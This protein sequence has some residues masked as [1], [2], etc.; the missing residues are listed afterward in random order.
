MT[1]YKDNFDDEIDLGKIASVFFLFGVLSLLMSWYYSSDAETLYK[2]SVRLNP[3]TPEL[4]L[5]PMKVAKKNTAY[6]ITVKTDLNIN[7]W[8]FVEGEILDQNKDYLYSFGK[9]LWHESGY[10]SDGSWT[11]SNNDY[12]LDVTFPTAG[13]YYLKFK[14]EAQRPPRS[15]T[16]KV[17]R[18]HGSAL[19]HF[20]F[21]VLSIII[22]IVLNEFKNR[23]IRRMCGE[24]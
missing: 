6:E 3:N 2:E 16:I 15:V 21:G 17:A 10:D 4:L 20:W 19:P 22:G 8:A 9:E 24:K 23:T 1:F 11:E 12:S 5:G 13:V 14:S 18:S 7:S